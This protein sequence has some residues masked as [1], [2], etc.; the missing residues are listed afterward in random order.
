MTVVIDNCGWSFIGEA[1]IGLNVLVGMLFVDEIVD[2][3]EWK[4]PT[5]GGVVAE[6]KSQE[7]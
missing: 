1:M 6:A 2:M 7:S 4:L 5:D 3:L